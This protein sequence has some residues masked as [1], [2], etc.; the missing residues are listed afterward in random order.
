MAFAK[1]GNAN[2]DARKVVLD[3]IAKQGD[4]KAF[5]QAQETRTATTYDKPLWDELVLGAD[6]RVVGARS[7][8]VNYLKENWQTLQKEA[9]VDADKLRTKMKVAREQAAKILEPLEAEHNAINET[10]ATVIGNVEPFTAESI[11]TSY[12][13]RA[14]LQPEALKAY[15]AHKTAQE[16]RY[17]KPAETSGGYKSIV[18]RH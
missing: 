7:D 13:Q 16:A 4:L 10:V 15:E 8:L 17:A 6:E 11:A 1:A 3:E 18:G 14:G 2:K 5:E 9:E 12:D